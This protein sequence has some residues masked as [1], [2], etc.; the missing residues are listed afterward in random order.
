VETNFVVWNMIGNAGLVAI[1]G[2][3]FRDWMIKKDKSDSDIKDELSNRVAEYRHDIKET[4]EKVDEGL[5]KIYEQMRIAN[6]RTSKIESQV[7][8]QAALCDERTKNGH[9]L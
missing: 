6:G 1:V 2:V 4:C 9:C 5:G 7:S 8:V 3:L